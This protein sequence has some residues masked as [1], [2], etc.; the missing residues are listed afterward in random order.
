MEVY[1]L[2]K[3]KIFGFVMSVSLL[4]GAMPGMGFTAYAQETS[5]GGDIHQDAPGNAGTADGWAYED[6][7]D[8]TLRITD[9]E[10]EETEPVVPAQ[11][12]EQT[13]TQIGDGALAGKQGIYSV[14]VSEG[15]TAVGE[16]AFADC[17]E[18]KSVELPDSVTSIG[19]RA[20]R[21]CSALQ[22]CRLPNTLQEFPYQCFWDCRSLTEITIP[23][24]V[25]DIP[26]GAFYNNWRLKRVTVPDSVTSIGKNA[27][28]A[29]MALYEL[30]LSENVAEIDQS[31]FSDCDMLV[32]LA[33][34]GSFAD[35]FAK[36]N[37]YIPVHAILESAHPYPHENQQWSYT[38]P[39]DAAALTVTFSSQTNFDSFWD[40]FTITDGAGIRYVYSGSK[41]AGETLVLAGNSFTMNLR[42]L[43]DK[44]DYFG[45]QITDIV[46]MT[47]EEYQAYLNELNANP[48]LTQV[49]NGTLE[50]TGYRGKMPDVVIPA[51]INGV[52]V[53]SIKNNAF[54][55]NNI[56]RMVTIE[57][58][59]RSIG[60]NAF[61][62]CENLEE[63]IL[64]DSVT[65]IGNYAFVGCTKLEKITLPKENVT[66]GEGM[67][68]D[69]ESLE[70]LVLP[71]GLT[72]MEDYLCNGCKSL[73]SVTLPD[74]L[75]EIGVLAFYNCIALEGL[76][77]P[78][79]L[80]AIRYEAFYTAGLT[81]LMIP[82]T[83]QTIGERAF[84]E[85]ENLTELTV[86]S[87]SPYFMARDNIVYSK[88]GE[89]LLCGAG[90]LTGVITIPDGVKKIGSDA[91]YYAEK[92]TKVILP[93]SLTE[94]DDSAFMGCKGLQEIVLPETITVL[95][96][97]VFCACSALEEL[98]VPAS[99]S[100]IRDRAMASCDN[101]KRVYI[102]DSVSFIEKSAF[103]N[104][105]K[106]VIYASADSTAFRC[107]QEESLKAIDAPLARA[108]LY[109]DG[110]PKE[111]ITAGAATG[112][113]LVYALGSGTDTP[114]E[115]SAFSEAIPTG[116]DAGSYAVWYM[117]RV[118]EDEND[119]EAQM[120]EA[121]ISEL[122]FGPADF[123][124]PAALTR[125]GE[126]AFAGAAMK[127]VYVP[128]GCTSIGANAFR[129]CTGLTQ[130]RLPKNCAISDTAFTGFTSLIAVYAPAGGTTDAWC[131]QANI[132]FVGE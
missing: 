14:S 56:L 71:E 39:E 6:V 41:L 79:G 131:A 127:I 95:P 124:L 121:T 90:G 86:D 29:C 52:S 89:T 1:S 18:L 82:S 118:G 19:R 109:A 37:G 68:E 93:D 119:P 20:F 129:N 83:L 85:C 76:A 21:Y 88:S 2:M 92:I 106:L 28:H 51:K 80:E 36:E 23:D 25:T 74:S 27:F 70:E 61:S 84:A 99:V 120:I 11:I 98:R 49:V 111:L 104:S 58:G 113:T 66:L 32:I 47:A 30:R 33:P 45:F 100:E 59:I 31:A 24:G 22:S 72:V 105:D 9:Y 10:G 122:A 67:F 8:G 117:L 44:K 40:K 87:S 130:I 101:L 107:A 42:V 96:E 50:I 75:K 53:A 4:L 34:E 46:P 35:T 94:L 110:T 5:T 115:A 123:T 15:I 43:E 62:R 132:P 69:C 126:E 3:R 97:Y 7:G 57:E 81:S 48:W 103:R 112:G 17:P 60:Y 116:T 73:R 63:V 78:E 38:H 26:N 64:P 114:P 55:D 91:F 12:G 108:G 13:V 65:E 16:E 54:T 125:L 128:N 77:L 102:P